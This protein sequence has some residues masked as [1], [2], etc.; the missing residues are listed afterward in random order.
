MCRGATWSSGSA[1]GCTAGSIWSRARRLG[2]D[3]AAR[4]VAHR[5][6]RDRLR[7]ALARRGGQRPGA[8]LVLRLRRAAERRRRCA[9]GLRGRRRRPRD[10]VGEAA[11]P[12]LVNALVATPQEHVLVL[13]DYHLI[14]E[15]AI[16]EGVRFVLAHLPRRLAH[17]DRDAGR[18]AGRRLPSAR[19][20]RARR[21][22]ER[23]AALQRRRGGGPAQRHARAGAARRAA[24]A[25][26][27]PGPRA[28]PPGSTSPGSR[29][30]TAQGRAAP[31]TSATTVT[32][33]TTSATRCC[34]RRHP[35]RGGSCSTP[36]CSTGSARRCVTRCAPTTRRGAARQ[37]ERA[38]L[39]LVPLDERGEWFRY[40][41]V[42]REVL[43]R[44]LAESRSEEYIAAL[45]ARAGAWCGGRRH[46][47]RDR[48][49][50][51]GRP[52]PRPT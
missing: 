8:L 44:E 24:R 19:A 33:S 42:F 18:A 3:D 48:P 39:F 51:R 37:I 35:R 40:H 22:D 13:D 31:T 46:L 1:M 17:G 20:R 30:A 4:R 43:R 15:P 32:S 41:H 12:L 2:Q 38:N 11:L 21:G 6:A 28:G 14:R 16:H 25:A 47:E 10:A 36:A 45:H 5:R 9:A 27:A 26:P 29:S 49:P 23:A 52:S 50:A 7:V 34:R